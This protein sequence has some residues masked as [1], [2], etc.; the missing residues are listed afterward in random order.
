MVKKSLGITVV[1]VL[2]LIVAGYFSYRYVFLQEEVNLYALIPEHALLVYESDNIVEDWQDIQEKTIW[3]NLQSIPAFAKTSSDIALLDSLSP[4]EK[5]LEALLKNRPFAVSMHTISKEEFDFLYIVKLDKV[6]DLSTAN[7]ILEAV[8]ENQNLQDQK[9]QFN[10]FEIYELR[11]REPAQTFTYIIYK[12]F[13]LGS[14]A[15]ILVEDAIRNINNGF[16]ASFLPMKEEIKALSKIDESSGKLYVNLVR[17]PDYFSL[18]TTE[19]AHKRN[20][21]NHFGEVAFLE[22][23]LKSEALLLNGFTQSGAFGNN[24]WLSTFKGQRPQPFGLANLLPDRTAILH[25]ITFDNALNWLVALQQFWLSTDHEQAERWD[26]FEATYGVSQEDIFGVLG[27]EIGLAVLESVEITAPDQLMYWQC[28]EVSRGLKMLD[29]LAAQVS[30]SEGDTVYSEEYG[31]VKIRQLNLQ[32]FP[33]KVFGEMFRGFE[34]C[35]YMPLDEFIVIGNSVQILKSLLNDI[36]QEATWGKSVKYNDFLSNAIKESNYNVMINVPKVWPA[37]IDGLDTKWESFARQNSQQLKQVELIG[38][39]FSNI[40]ND[41]YTSVTLKHGTPVIARSRTGLMNVHHVYLENPITT[42]PFIVRNHTN[43]SKEV[44]LQDAADIAYLISSEGRILWRDSLEGPVLGEVSQV[45]YYGNGKLQYFFGTEKGIHIIDREG[46]EVSGFPLYPGYKIAQAAVV[47]YDNSK[48]YRFLVSDEH[49]NI[50]MY[51]KQGTNLEGWRPLKMDHKLS[52]PPG[53]LRVRG[54]DFIYAVQENGIV[55]VMTRRGEM[56]PGFPL[57]LGDKVKGPVFIEIGANIAQTR[58][59]T[60]T[61]TGLLVQF[62]LEGKI[63]NREQ[64]YKPSAATTFRIIPGA[65]GKGF[66]ILRQDMRRVAILNRRGE[67]LFEKDY[68]SS[69]EMKAQYYF[70]GAENAIVAIT[71]PVQSFTYIYDLSGNLINGQP[72][73]SDHEIGLLYYENTNSFRLYSTYDRKFSL[74]TF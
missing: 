32:E 12:N 9:R 21:V 33:A 72:M 42:K 17:A 4:K 43:S 19:G 70:F 13:F 50:Y 60:V 27:K 24:D 45:D 29:E 65:L 66:V 69:E 6:D 48:R 41:F 63:L 64:L 18:F 46:N 74:E 55:K 10:G 51:D 38:V 30:A 3:E 2:L 26:D 67:T 11:K 22:V 62:N 53:H 31:G 47:D 58:F 68:L 40:E 15:P 1:V 73:E 61:E 14:F 7:D 59:V 16:T 35:F 5:P 25:H 23:N 57:V 20:I 37:F 39:Q 36:E 28:D 34:A 71:D 44:F 52:A 8:K 49:G 56:Y 54:K